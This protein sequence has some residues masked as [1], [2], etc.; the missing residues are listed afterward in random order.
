[1]TLDSAQ[2]ADA[3]PAVTPTAV[4]RETV[5]LD[6]ALQGGG[7]HGAFTWGV[8]DR[9]LEEPWLEIEAAS[10][11]SAGAMNAVMLAHGLVKGDRQLAQQTLGT[12]WRRI[13]DT[14]MEAP[15]GAGGRGLLDSHAYFRPLELMNPFLS[16][17]FGRR[18][19]ESLFSGLFSPYQFN[20]L[21][22]NPL[23]DILR[24]M[25]DFE[26]LKATDRIK[27]FISATRVADGELKL[28]RNKDLSA[29]AI[30]ASACLPELFQAVKIGGTA[31]WDGGYVANPALEPL[32]AETKSDDLLLIQL[33]PTSREALPFSAG[34]ISGRL[35][36]ITFN[37]NLNAMLHGIAQ[38]K[39]ALT[40]ESQSGDLKNAFFREV[41][42]LRLHR[43][44]ADAS[45]FD[46][47]GSTKRNPRWE[48]LRSLH[49]Q[50]VAAADIWLST[51]AG[52][53][54]QMSTL[55]C[56]ML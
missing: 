32:I 16:P 14:A 42:K 27:L 50:G 12:F 36:E 48:L 41:Q 9:L 39:I 31:Y 30:M 54:G 53:L 3:A 46:L 55:D 7:A 15:F 29:E 24:D 49:D 34:E 45:S 44:A 4:P 47:G 2:T 1:M 26:A 19:A 10:G 6:V 56:R 21:N 43:I 22:W 25:V 28:F 8:L 35:N 38:L 13:A 18:V 40:E 23:L 5:T 33:N 37:A 17:D 51:H 20:P 52:C 11:A